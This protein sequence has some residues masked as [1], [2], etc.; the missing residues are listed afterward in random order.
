MVVQ[1]YGGKGADEDA[2]LLVLGHLLG[3]D[4]VQGMVALQY[5]DIALADADA[6]VLVDTLAQLEVVARQI[7]LLAR[8]QLGHLLVEQCRIHGTYALEIVI[9]IG[10]LGCV[11]TVHEI[12]VRADG[13]RTHAGGHQ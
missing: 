13:V 2:V 6:A 10:I 4:G 8:Q 3:Q 11:H 7:H 1:G 12:V 9:A 5:N